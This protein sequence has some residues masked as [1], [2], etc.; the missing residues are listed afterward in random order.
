MSVYVGIRSNHGRMFLND[1]DALEYAF[2]TCNI[3]PSEDVNLVDS[4]FSEMLLDWFY[5]YDWIRREEDEQ[6]DNPM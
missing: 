6:R 2:N 4:D 3:E 5:S 1:D